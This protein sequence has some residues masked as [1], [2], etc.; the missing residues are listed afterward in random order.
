MDLKS[1]RFL[2]GVKQ[3]KLMGL[4]GINQA[5]ISAIELGYV[6]ANN[7]ERSQI[8]KALGGTPITWDSFGPEPRQ[9]RRT[10]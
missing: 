8:E 9:S 5:R 7:Y 1:A 3:M 6:R 2:V 10:K 4:T